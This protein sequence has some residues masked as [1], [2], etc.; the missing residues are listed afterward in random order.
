V[1]FFVVAPVVFVIFH[2]YVFLQ[3]YALAK[4]AEEYN[5]LLK[6]QVRVDADRHRVRQRLDT[7]LILQ[8][9]AGPK[10]QRTHFQG[11]AL[12]LIAWITL[13]GAPIL[14]LLQAQVTF[15]PYHHEQ[16]AWAQRVLLAIDLAVIW[17]FWDRVRGQDDPI[18][19]GVL[20]P[21][22]KTVGLALTL[23]VA[24]FSVLVATYPGEW[25]D[26]H[27][28]R[29]LSDVTGWNPLH[30]WL[31][32]GEVNEVSGKP[33]SLFSNRL[34]PTDQS[35][36]D[37]EKLDKVEVSRPFRGRDL[38]GAVLNRADLRKADFTGAMLDAAELK[39]ANLQQARF[40][41]ASRAG[42]LP[43][44][45]SCRGSSSAGSESGLRSETDCASLQ[46][47]SLNG[48]WLQGASLNGALLQGASLL[49][50]QLQGAS[51]I[52]GAAARGIA[53]SGAAARGVAR[54]GATARDGVR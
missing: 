19:G 2:F 14:I 48:A 31:F 35:F 9:L 34:V 10:E 21:V 4:K 39:A 11:F 17:A 16:V 23:C 36:V 1:A 6:Q 40:G 30:D 45:D 27:R 46:G 3:I 41:Y 42:N 52:E 29:V 33:R 15:L 54:L 43:R 26:D 22:W 25:A 38:R 13:V 18:L 8:F 44:R 24:L 53:R 28:R 49:S 47:A 7:F 5:T 32:A 12:R 50:A 51:L 20:T 37:S